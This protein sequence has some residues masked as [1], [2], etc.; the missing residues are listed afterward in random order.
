MTAEQP[1]LHGPLSEEEYLEKP[2]VKRRLGSGGD[3]SKN[4][5]GI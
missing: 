3:K 2:K 5:R 4:A 1:A